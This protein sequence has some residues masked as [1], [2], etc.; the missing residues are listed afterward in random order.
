[1]PP[2]EEA[3][4][5]GEEAGE[6]RRWCL[7]Q[8]GG[9]SRGDRSRRS[10]SRG[11]RPSRSGG[12]VEFPCWPSPALKSSLATPCRSA[13]VQSSLRLRRCSARRRKAP[14]AEERLSSCSSE[15]CRPPHRHSSLHCNKKLQ[16][17]SIPLFL[18]IVSCLQ[19]QISSN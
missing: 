18:I 10:R 6:Q 3:G 15:L 7:Q 14:I 1:V 17:R 5:S 16:M 11:G 19:Q 8:R 2:G 4:P 13:A 9:R 12:E